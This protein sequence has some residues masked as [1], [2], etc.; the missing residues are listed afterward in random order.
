MSAGAGPERVVVAMSG[1]VDSSLAAALVVASGAEAIC[2]RV[3]PSLAT[4]VLISAPLSGAMRSS[5]RE[6]S[7]SM[8]A[9]VPVP[10]PSTSIR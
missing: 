4:Q 7:C 5:T 3:I 9:A 2:S 10:M 8:R 1:G 6:P